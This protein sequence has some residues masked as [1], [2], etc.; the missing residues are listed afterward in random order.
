MVPVRTNF[1]L[2]ELAHSDSARGS[3][4][5]WVVPVDCP[6]II[7]GVYVTRQSLLK[8]MELVR[9]YEVH[10]ARQCGVVPFSTQIMCIR[11]KIGGQVACIV[12][13]P[14]FGGQ[15]ARHHREPGRSAQRRVA[16]GRV[17][18]HCVLGQAV[19]SGCLDGRG[20]IVLDGGLRCGFNW[21]FRIP[22]HHL[23]Q[24]SGHLVRHDIEYVW[25]RPCLS[26]HSGSFDSVTNWERSTIRDVRMKEKGMGEDSVFMI[27]RPSTTKFVGKR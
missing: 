20:R 5:Y 26:C 11:R 7:P 27:T 6:T 12:V 3:P 23:Q 18:D 9:A 19:K 24:R 1:L 10:L 15:L 4:T 17:E 8:S 2:D 16:V 25:P 21:G 22:A 14:N 13:S